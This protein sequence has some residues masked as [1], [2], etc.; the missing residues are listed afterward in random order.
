MNLGL[1]PELGG[2]SLLLLRLWLPQG[3]GQRKETRAMAGPLPP[4]LWDSSSP[5]LQSQPCCYLSLPACGLSETRAN[6]PALTSDEGPLWNL[7]PF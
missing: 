2:P 6:S 5:R 3:P 1:V 4:H 7:W